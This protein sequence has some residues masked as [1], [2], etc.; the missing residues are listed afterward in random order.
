MKD[1]VLSVK[2]KIGYGMGDGATLTIILALFTLVPAERVFLFHFCTKSNIHFSL[3]T[4]AADA[5]PER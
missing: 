4:Q 3:V 5:I 1:P 2:E